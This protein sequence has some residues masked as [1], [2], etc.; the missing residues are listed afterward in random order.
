MR[1]PLCFPVPFKS[2]CKPM[3]H[4]NRSGILPTTVK[5]RLSHDLA[6]LRSTSA[7]NRTGIQANDVVLAGGNEERFTI[8]DTNAGSCASLLNMFGID[9]GGQPHPHVDTVRTRPA[10]TPK[11]GYDFI[12]GGACVLPTVAVSIARFLQGE[13]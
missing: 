7:P 13:V 3:L 12:Q 10:A 8:G 6:G 11:W 4:V 1:L 5:N 2:S 9:S